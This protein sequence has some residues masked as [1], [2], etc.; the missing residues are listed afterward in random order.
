KVNIGI[1]LE[2]LKDVCID[3]HFVE[4]ERFLRLSQ[5]LALNPVIIGIGIEEDTSV[6]ITHGTNVKIVGSGLIIIIEGY[7][8]TKTNMDEYESSNT[9]SIR[10]LK[11]HILSQGDEYE[12]RQLNPPH[13]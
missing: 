4:R 13:K 7:D 6:V 11:V 12:I 3:T 1:G 2:F 8:I 10:D 5:V 9:L